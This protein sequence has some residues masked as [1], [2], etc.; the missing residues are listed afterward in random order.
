MSSVVHPELKDFEYECDE[1]GVPLFC[2]FE[3]EP[4]QIGAREPGS[5]IQLE[6]DYPATYTLCHAYLPGSDVDISPVLYPGLIRHIEEKMED[7]CQGW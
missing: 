3:Y 6:P 1:L 5:G 4:A 7:F 2:W